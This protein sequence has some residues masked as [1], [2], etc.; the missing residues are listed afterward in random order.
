MLS[1]PSQSGL[2]SFS[3]LSRSSIIWHQPSIWTVFLTT[4]WFVP[5][6]LCKVIS[7]KL[8]FDFPKLLCLKCP[9]FSLL[10]S[11][12]AVSSL[13]FAVLFNLIAAHCSKFLKPFVVSAGWATEVLE[14]RQCLPHIKNGQVFPRATVTP[15][16]CFQ[17]L[18]FSVSVMVDWTEQA[19]CVL[20]S[21]IWAEPSLR[22]R[23]L[24][25]IT[26]SGDMS[27]ASFR[28]WWRA[29][30]P[31]VMQSMGSQIVE[32]DWATEQQQQTSE[33]HSPPGSSVLGILQARIRE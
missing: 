5:S 23:W 4:G 27:W 26:D 25:G 28:S 18:Q 22:T 16:E 7:L 20:E 13:K 3:W 29:G 10:Y 8:I 21:A 9:T 1:F 19:L 32:H 14:A 6:A 17:G 12:V 31:G 33:D 15:A 24:D 30:K 2:N 11:G